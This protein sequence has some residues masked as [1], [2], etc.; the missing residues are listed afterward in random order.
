MRIIADKPIELLRAQV[1]KNLIRVIPL[2]GIQWAVDDSQPLPDPSRYVSMPNEL[3]TTPIDLATIKLDPASFVPVDLKTLNA[4][5]VLYGPEETGV[6]YD[7]VA[8]IGPDLPE[9]PNLYLVTSDG[10]VVIAVHTNAAIHP[11]GVIQV[12]GAEA[13]IALLTIAQLRADRGK[14]LL[15]SGSCVKAF[16]IERRTDDGCWHPANIEFNPGAIALRE[17]RTD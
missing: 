3:Q 9:I 10:V 14:K 7:V 16:G 13:G 6:R 11:D 4:R 1:N 15:S 17:L 5:M 12:W 2:D 8:A